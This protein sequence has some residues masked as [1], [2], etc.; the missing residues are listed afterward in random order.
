MKD[1]RERFGGHR[2][3]FFGKG[4]GGVVGIF[5]I[6]PVCKLPESREIRWKRRASFWIQWEPEGVERGG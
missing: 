5:A 2:L 1:R 4:A 6:V 3:I